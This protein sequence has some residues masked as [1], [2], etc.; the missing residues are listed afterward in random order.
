MLRIVL[1]LALTSLITSTAW[2]APITID[3]F[4]DGNPPR[5]GPSAILTRTLMRL[6][7]LRAEDLQAPVTRTFR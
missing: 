3:D 1:T 2:A 6:R 5:A 4:E 7:I